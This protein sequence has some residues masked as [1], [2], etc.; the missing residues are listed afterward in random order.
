M[1]VWV[2]LHRID[3]LLEDVGVYTSA[4]AAEGAVYRQ[5]ADLEAGYD[6]DEDEEA[7]R[8]NGLWYDADGAEHIFD[9]YEQ[10]VES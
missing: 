7:G 5:T 2:L 8:A 9:V 1:K 10:E 6:S 3:A 4:K